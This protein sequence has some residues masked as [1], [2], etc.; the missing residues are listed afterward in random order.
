MG[1]KGTLR[2]RTIRILSLVLAL[3][4]LLTACNQGMPGQSGEYKLQA[5]SLSWDGSQYRFAWIDRDGSVKWAEGNDVQLMQD[6]RT[7]LEMRDGRPIVHLTTDEPV[8]VLGHDGNGNFSN[9]WFPFLVGSMLGGRDR[10]VVVN[11][12]YPGTAQVPTDR[13]AYRYPPTDSFGRGETL[14]GSVSNSRPAAPDYQ[15]VAPI[16]G[17]RSGQT[18]GAGGGSGATNK[19]P[20][21]SSGQVGGAGSGAAASSKGTGAASGISGGTGAGSAASSK[22]SGIGAGAGSGSGFSG[23]KS[24]GGFSGGKS[25]GG[26]SGGRRR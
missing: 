4:V 9:M 14:Q 7:Y 17:A 20:S 11:Q 6:Q 3:A 26:F 21:Y 25:S 22:G 16:A 18:G 8:Q 13:P 19:A 12:P 2:S 5:H 15:K 10:T 1:A 23:G 24:S